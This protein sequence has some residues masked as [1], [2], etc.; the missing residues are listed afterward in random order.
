MSPTEV[1][2]LAKSSTA[3]KGALNIP[4]IKKPLKASVLN[5][6]QPA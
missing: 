5:Y 4:M 3:P 6:Q 2:W 1:K